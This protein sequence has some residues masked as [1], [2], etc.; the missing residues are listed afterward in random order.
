[1]NQIIFI[2]ILNLIFANQNKEDKELPP[3]FD[4]EKGI[5]IGS[6]IPKTMSDEFYRP[7]ADYEIEK[8]KQ[9]AKNYIPKPVSDEPFTYTLI[10]EVSINEFSKVNL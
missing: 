2:I 9:T 1:M 4:F 3:R 5:N 7:I 8:I 6:V 10:V